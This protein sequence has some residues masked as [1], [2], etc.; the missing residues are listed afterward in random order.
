MIGGPTPVDGGF[1]AVI[2]RAGDEPLGAYA[3]ALLGLRD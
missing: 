1:G 2:E 3:Q